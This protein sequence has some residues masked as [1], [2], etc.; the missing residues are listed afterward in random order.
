MPLGSRVENGHMIKDTEA[1]RKDKLNCI[2]M[3][4]VSMNVLWQEVN[5]VLELLEFTSEVSVGVKPVSFF[6][7]KL[8]QEE[9]GNQKP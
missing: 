2:S 5:R 8:L 9:A 1:E 6:D 3:E 7:I 4:K